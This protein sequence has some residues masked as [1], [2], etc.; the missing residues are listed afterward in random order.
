MCSSDLCACT[1][2]RT[3]SC[4]C[5]RTDLKKV[6]TVR[7]GRVLAAMS[8]SEVKLCKALG[9]NTSQRGDFLPFRNEKMGEWVPLQFDVTLN[10]Q[11]LVHEQQ[12]IT[13]SC[14]RY[15]SI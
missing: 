8:V 3:Y 10:N 11:Q 14:V 15:S 12:L 2:S 4:T 13:L 9:I 1:C 7:G 5:V 6:D